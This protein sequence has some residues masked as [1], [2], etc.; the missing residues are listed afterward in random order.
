MNS[1]SY[2]HRMTPWDEQR[3]FALIPRLV[4]ASALPPLIEESDRL[5]T[6]EGARSAGVRHVLRRSPTFAEFAAS[7]ALAELVAPILGDREFIVR[8]LLFDKT[9]QANWDVPWHQDTT[10]AVAQRAEVAGFGPWSIKD[11]S[12]HV[13]P[14]AGVLAGML[15]VRI[16]IDASGDDNGPLLVAPGSHL[17]GVRGDVRDI[18]AFEAAKVACVTEAGGAVLMRPLLFHAS[19]KAL[20]PSHRRVLHLEYAAHDLPHPLEWAPDIAS[21]DSGV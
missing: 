12:P 14:P 9:P 6:L 15:A 2:A 5:F 10:I 13:R 3:G 18:T 19:R 7:G 16:N 20:R 8:S 1:S 11:G 17:S 4:A 21:A